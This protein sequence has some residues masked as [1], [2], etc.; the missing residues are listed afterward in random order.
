MQINEDMELNGLED[1][2]MFKVLNSKMGINGI[3]IARL[4]VNG[5]VSKLRQV[6]M[7]LCYCQIDIFAITETHLNWKT[8][9][10]EI[11]VDGYEIERFDREGKS[12]GGSLLY[13]RS[14]LTVTPVKEVNDTKETESV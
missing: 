14:C 12:G 3:K 1:K 6:E 10:N 8:S 9:D 2:D 5:L 13:Y 11:S 7:L 4:N